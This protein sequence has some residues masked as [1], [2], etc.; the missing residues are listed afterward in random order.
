MQ[1][2][3][4]SQRDKWLKEKSADEK[5][6][7]RSP[8]SK[9]DG[10]KH[11]TLTSSQELANTKSELSKQH[12]KVPVSSQELVNSIIKGWTTA[13]AHS[14]HVVSKTPSCERYLTIW[15]KPESSKPIPE[16]TVNIHF[17][18][19][20]DSVTN[21]KTVSYRVENSN[22]IHTSG[23]NIAFTDAW[24]DNVIRGKMLA[25]QSV[26]PIVV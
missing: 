7:S 18:V 15:S 14:I 5:S 6:H 23:E 19:H 22:F 21:K 16:H 20:I 9:H 10:K 11:N 3:R 13:Y 1:E 4:D 2:Y 25:K 17:E 12:Q 26:Y 24:L 8:N